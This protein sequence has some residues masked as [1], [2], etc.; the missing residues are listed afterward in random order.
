MTYVYINATFSYFCYDVISGKINDRRG[1]CISITVLIY[2]GFTWLDFLLIIRRE[3]FEYS[4]FYIFLL[5]LIDLV[6]KR[7]TKHFLRFAFICRSVISGDLIRNWWSIRIIDVEWLLYVLFVYSHIFSFYC[8][9]IHIRNLLLTIPNR[10]YAK[11][12][13]LLRRNIL[14]LCLN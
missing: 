7:A 6:P 11:I 14:W 4:L 2:Y 13:F 12:T 5:I 8:Y 10:T 9:I 1:K 3:F